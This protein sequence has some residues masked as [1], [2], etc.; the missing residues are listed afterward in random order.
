MACVVFDYPTENPPAGSRTLVCTE[1]RAE[2]SSSSSQQHA[3]LQQI[4]T[5][6]AVRVAGRGSAPFGGV[7]SLSIT[8]PHVAHISSP[9]MSDVLV[10]K[11][12][13]STCNNKGAQ[14][15]SSYSPAVPATG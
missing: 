13:A 4:S 8:M 9:Q 3:Q 14:T 12:P 6:R 2:L 5:L 7:V 11:I 1:C 15:S 10:S